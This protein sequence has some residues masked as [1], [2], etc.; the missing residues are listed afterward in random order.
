MYKANVEAVGVWKFTI[1]DAKTGKIK[2]EKITKNII[3]TIGRTAIACQLANQQTYEMGAKYI[4]IGTGTTP[5]ANGDTTLET[6]V[7]R[8]AV[9][10]DAYANNVAYI[11]GFFTADEDNGNYKEFGIFGDGIATESSGSVDTGIL[12]SRVLESIDK[13]ALE[14]LTVEWSITFV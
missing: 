3:P 5:A 14:T 7:Y 13:S 6:E 1:R 10:S 8:K 9:S 12:Y 4:A 2:R 11:A